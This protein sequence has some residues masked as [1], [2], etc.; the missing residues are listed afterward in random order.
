MTLFERFKLVQKHILYPT[1]KYFE[2][3]LEKVNEIWRGGIK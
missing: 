3:S 1:K 2:I